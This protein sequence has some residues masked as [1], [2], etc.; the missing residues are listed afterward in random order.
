MAGTSNGKYRRRLKQQFVAAMGIDSSTLGVVGFTQTAYSNGDGS[1]G[2]SSETEDPI[3]HV[4][5][6]ETPVPLSYILGLD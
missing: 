4:G 3:S 6:I 1:K 2:S 5:M